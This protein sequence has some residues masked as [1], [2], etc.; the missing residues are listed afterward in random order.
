MK[1]FCPQLSKKHYSGFHSTLGALQMKIMGDFFRSIDWWKI[2][3][4][5]MIFEKWINGN[6]AY[7]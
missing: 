2:V 6:V 1:V 5:Q 3:H 7:R 4:D